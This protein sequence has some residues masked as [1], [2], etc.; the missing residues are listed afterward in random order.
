MD[1][2][3]KFSI[4]QLIKSYPRISALALMLAV[5]IPMMLTPIGYL[6]INPIVVDGERVIVMDG[7]LSYDADYVYEVFDR[8]GVEGRNMYFVFH[9]NRF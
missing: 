3:K 7:L 5:A 8:L 6:A 9:K 4:I 2:K 1:V